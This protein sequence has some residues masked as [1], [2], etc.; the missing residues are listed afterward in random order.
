MRERNEILDEHC[1][2]IGRDPESIR[3]SLYYW[4]PR[5]EDDPWRSTDAFLE[6]IGRY[7]DVGVNEFILDHPRDDQLD[8]CERVAADLLPR[9]RA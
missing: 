9:L 1:A 7:R 2:R 8:V 4:V 3:R 5:S 6:V